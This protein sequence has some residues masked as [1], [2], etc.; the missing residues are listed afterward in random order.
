MLNLLKQLLQQS[1]QQISIK[2]K[3]ETLLG[4]Y[5]LNKIYPFKQLI[6]FINNNGI[7]QNFITK[8]YC[9]LNNIKQLPKCKICNKQLTKIKNFVSGFSQTCSNKCTCL[10]KYGVISTACLPEIQKKMKISILQ[11]N[12]GIGF[13]SQ[14]IKEKAYNSMQ[15]KYGNIFIKTQQFKEKT[16]QTNLQ[17]YNSQ[18]FMKTNN[19]KEK[20]KNS[21]LKKYD[22]ENFMQTQQGKQ[23]AKNNFKQSNLLLGRKKAYFNRML[24]ILNNKFKP[25]FSIENFYGVHKKYMFQCLSCNCKFQ[26]SLINLLNRQLLTCPNCKIFVRSIIQHQFKLQLENIF[27]IKFEEDFKLKNNKEL[28]IFNIEKN[29]GIEYN[30]NYWHSDKVL[31]NSQIN[32]FEKFI[33]LKNN[34]INLLAIWSDE[35]Q[36]FKNYI[37]LI[38]SQILNINK[39]FK[40]Q[41]FIFLTKKFKKQKIKTFNNIAIKYLQFKNIIIINEISIKQFIEHPKQQFNQLIKIFLN[42][43]IYFYFEN[44]LISFYLLFLSNIQFIKIKQPKYYIFNT[45]RTIETYKNSSKSNKIWNY[46]IFFI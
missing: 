3:K 15:Q 36:K 38:T 24:K 21:L 16:L 40:Q 44:R 30:G 11:N 4:N 8:I 7:G 42:K 23:I 29:F 26:S 5:L 43:N 13:G 10:L 22:K 46:R 39:N 37:F 45:K 25:L 19:G 2:N 34:N 17:K 20:L 18:H 27:N 33:Y 41:Q 14:K 1:K 31:K 28:D 35:F 6:Y 32:H 12:N 9:L